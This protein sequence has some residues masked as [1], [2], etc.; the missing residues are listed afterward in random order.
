[1]SREKCELY[2]A[3]D[4]VCLP[5]CWINETHTL[6]IVTQRRRMQGLH[7]IT[8]LTKTTSTTKQA[9]GF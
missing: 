5:G 7:R 8:G 3:K 1:V 9:D 4:L 2:F 6:S